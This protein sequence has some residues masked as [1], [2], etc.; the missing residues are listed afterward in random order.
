M[1]IPA[2]VRIP[3]LIEWK[4]VNRVAPHHF[5]RVFGSNPCR[6]C[7]NQTQPRFTHDID[8]PLLVISIV[9]SLICTYRGLPPYSLIAESVF[10]KVEDVYARFP[11]TTVPWKLRWAFCRPCRGSHLS[12]ESR[13]GLWLC[14]R[15]PVLMY[16][17][18]C[19]DRVGHLY[20]NDNGLLPSVICLPIEEVASWEWIRRICVP[21]FHLRYT[22]K[23]DVEE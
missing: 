8:W 7:S 10:L 19:Y 23:Q 13:P 20:S 14:R 6:G 17:Y 21:S 16:L 4:R 11:V 15:C 9:S 1:W 2:Q 5:L 22:R 3:P 12:P 18:G